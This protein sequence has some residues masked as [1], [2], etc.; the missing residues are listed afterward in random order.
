M[1]Y[2]NHEQTRRKED[3]ERKTR[4]TFPTSLRKGSSRV[5]ESETEAKGK[6]A[7]KEKV[8]DQTKAQ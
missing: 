5:P 1:L 6:E 3:H 7:E 8:T 4:F 2:L